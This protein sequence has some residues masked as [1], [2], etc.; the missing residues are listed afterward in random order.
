MYGRIINV[1][2]KQMFSKN[3]N[4][5]SYNRT[6]LWIRKATAK[7]DIFVKLFYSHPNVS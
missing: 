4:T 5:L 2:V 1:Y 6:M 3:N 7:F